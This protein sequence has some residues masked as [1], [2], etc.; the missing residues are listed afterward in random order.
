M[1]LSLVNSIVVAMNSDRVL[2]GVFRLYPS[3]VAG[4][5]KH[6]EE[7]N[8]YVLCNYKLTYVEYI[9]KAILSEHCTA[10]YDS[11]EKY[12]FKLSSGRETILLKFETGM[13]E[14]NYHQY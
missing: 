11:C 12:Y 4:I 10:S 6:V 7:I 3:F 8:F 9:V 2:C 5:L 14:E 13:M 1:W